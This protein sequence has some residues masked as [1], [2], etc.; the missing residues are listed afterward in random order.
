MIIKEMIFISCLILSLAGFSA[1]FDRSAVEKENRYVPAIYP[2]SES[3]LKF[4]PVNVE[5]EPNRFVAK[6]K[7]GTYYGAAANPWFLKLL[8]Q[9]NKDTFPLSKAEVQ[10][11]PQGISEQQARQ[12]LQLYNDQNYAGTKSRLRDF[13]AIF[14]AKQNLACFSYGFHEDCLLL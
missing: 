12:A 13:S 9:K 10:S 11:K 3:D 4:T 8:P 1:S 7:Y 14:S 6:T 2:Y 5:Y